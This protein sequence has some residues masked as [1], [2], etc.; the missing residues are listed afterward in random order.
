MTPRLTPEEKQGRDKY[1][2]RERERIQYHQ[3]E[4]DLLEAEGLLTEAKVH[5]TRVMTLRRERRGFR[6]KLRRMR[7][8]H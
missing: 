5:R 7:S 1:F 2:N 3:Q 4:A 6:R 8:T